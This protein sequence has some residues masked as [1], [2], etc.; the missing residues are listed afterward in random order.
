MNKIKT[1]FI[2]PKMIF[3]YC[4]SLGS[5]PAD[6]NQFRS[7]TRNLFLLFNKKDNI[8]KSWLQRDLFVC[9]FVSQYA[10]REI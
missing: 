4:L 6:D 10:M 7:H 3:Q 8:Y 2:S 1:S 5:N 9:P